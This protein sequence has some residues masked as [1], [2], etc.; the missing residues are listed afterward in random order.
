MVDNLIDRVECI[1]VAPDD[2]NT[3][4][5]W[6]DSPVEASS[7]WSMV[8]VDELKP[9]IDSLYN[10]CPGRANTGV[11]G[12]SMGGFGAL[13]NL[14]EHPEVFG[15]AFSM[16]GAV[17]LMPYAG[18][19]GLNAVLGEQRKHHGNWKAVNVVDHVCELAEKDVSIG[20]YS[21][22]NDWFYEDNRKLHRVL[23]SC[24][25]AHQWIRNDEPHFGIPQE[26]M[27]AVL[28]FFDSVFV[29]CSP[30]STIR[31]H[32]ALRPA[33]HIPASPYFRHRSCVLDV[34]GRRVE[35]PHDAAHGVGVLI[36]Y[37]AACR[38][39]MAVGLE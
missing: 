32:G 4:R 12:H 25:I 18:N 17:D 34:K 6:L 24:G 16:K 23:D 27:F 3:L 26:S 33:G 13:H 37:S 1:A 31:R 35:R 21:G 20:F 2:G 19:W 15:A 7:K 14:I 8:L 22:P 11:A 29:S 39:W 38:G 36:T 28:S 10:T 9:R 5:W 30:T